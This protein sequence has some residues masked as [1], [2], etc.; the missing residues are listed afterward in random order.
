VTVFAVEVPALSCEM[1]IPAPT[2]WRLEPLLY[3]FTLD[4]HHVSWLILTLD[5]NLFM[6]KQSHLLSP[7]LAYRTFTIIMF[8]RLAFESFSSVFPN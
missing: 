4:M 1:I 3:S 8:A 7:L 5:L 6:Y 2:Y